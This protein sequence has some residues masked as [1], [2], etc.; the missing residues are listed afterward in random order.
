METLQR[1]TSVSFVSMRSDG[2]E[3]MDDFH[4]DIFIEWVRR[5]NINDES[6]ELMVPWVREWYYRNKEK[7]Y[8]S[9]NNS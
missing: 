5:G 1:K 2:I 3:E 8:D 9:S 6:I 7:I 4:T